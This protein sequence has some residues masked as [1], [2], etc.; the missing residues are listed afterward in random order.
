MASE[1][2]IRLHS[3]FLI[4]LFSIFSKYKHR[5]LLLKSSLLQTNKIMRFI[6]LKEDSQT[7]FFFMMLSPLII[8][9]SYSIHSLKRLSKVLSNWSWISIVNKD[10]KYSWLRNGCHNSKNLWTLFC[11]ILSLDLAKKSLFLS[12]M[13]KISKYRGSAYKAMSNNWNN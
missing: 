9:D 10:K 12:N 8:L 13:I 7:L 3:N 2:T 1:I 11:N 4:T 6:V 5:Y